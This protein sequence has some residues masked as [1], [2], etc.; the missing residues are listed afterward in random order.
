MIDLIGEKEDGKMFMRQKNEKIE[1][2]LTSCI[3]CAVRIAAFRDED[4]RMHSAYITW[5]SQH[6]HL[7]QNSWRGRL[8]LAYLA[9]RGKNISDIDLNTTEDILA[10]DRA[11]QNI[12]GW[13]KE[14]NGKNIASESE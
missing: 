5:L 10:F 3:E 13:F 6:S 2:F 9:L 4:E 1:L 8:K 14:E 12:V 7:Y 11:W